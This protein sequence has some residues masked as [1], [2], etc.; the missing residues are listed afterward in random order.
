MPDILAGW[1]GKRHG[2]T[3]R[4]LVN[5]VN[6][7]V[8][9]GVQVVSSADIYPAFGMEVNLEA[10]G[11]RV[12]RVCFGNVVRQSSLGSNPSQDQAA[13]GDNNWYCRHAS[14]RKK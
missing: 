9:L 8:M 6:L 12:C 14:G 1:A 10:A 11:R 4:H 5:T 13:N 2:S 7:R 3:E